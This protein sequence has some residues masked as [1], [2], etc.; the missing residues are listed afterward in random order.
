MSSQ[1]IRENDVSVMSDNRAAFRLVMRGY[2][3]AEVDRRLAELTH[4][5]VAAQQH[6][7]DLHSQVERLREG[8]SAAAPVPTPAADFA[9]LGV[10]IG[11]ILTA[12]ERAAAEIGEEAAKDAQA[13]LAEADVTIG[14][15]QAEAELQAA[16]IIEEATQSAARRLPEPEAKFQQRIHAADEQ[17][18]SARQYATKLRTE[19][20][21][22]CEEAARQSAALTA[23]SEQKAHE[24]V[25]DATNRATEIKT[26]SEHELAVA[27]EHR[28]T[29]ITELTKIRKVLASA[30]HG[31]EAEAGDA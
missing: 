22:S 28:D 8:A 15:K 24:L 30:I 6:A 1:P 4:A 13:K 31:G 7:S 11:Q 3:P 14:E 17:L 18:S 25:A 12:A 2:D 27:T 9:S 16:A 20:D 29:V 23:E 26:A 21:R 5:T 10:H 19:T